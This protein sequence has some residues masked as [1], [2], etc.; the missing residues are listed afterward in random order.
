MKPGPMIRRNAKIT[1]LCA[2]LLLGAALAIQSPGVQARGWNWAKRL[3][4]S[5]YT[6]DD[7]AIFHAHVNQALNDA[8]DGQRVEWKNPDSGRSGAITPLTTETRGDLTCRRARFESRAK[9]AEN[10][11]EFLVCRQADGR[12][13][14]Q[15]GAGLVEPQ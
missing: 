3:P 11:S 9:Q 13:S 15:D 5:Q 14:V 7:N 1:T 6:A 2:L 10:V 4:L 12:W 8:A